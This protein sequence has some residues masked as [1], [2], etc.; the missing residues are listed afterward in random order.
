MN[1]GWPIIIFA[2]AKDFSHYKRY[3]EIQR[4]F[5]ITNPKMS[6][7]KYEAAIDL[8]AKK[9]SFPSYVYEELVISQR[10]KFVAGEIIK[11][12]RQEMLDLSISVEL[13]SN[14]VVVHLWEILKNKLDKDNAGDMT[15]AYRLYPPM[16]VTVSVMPIG[17][18]SIRFDE[19]N[20]QRLADSRYQFP[21]YC[22]YTFHK[23]Q[24]IRAYFY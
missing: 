24:Y 18:L 11:Q 13:G 1:G 17:H 4:C 14:N 6:K 22:V 15:N 12:L 9:F 5:I 20:G 8:I 16:V 21:Q 10:E 23:I 2:Q 7:E 19:K 3:P